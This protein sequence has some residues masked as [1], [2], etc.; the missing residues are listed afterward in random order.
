M[1]RSTTTPG[2]S[3]FM[4]VRPGRG[5]VRHVRAMAASLACVATAFGAHIISGGHASGAAVVTVFV[6][7]GA[8]AWSLAGARLTR[9]QLLG[10][11]VLCQVGVHG[12]SMAAET[13]Q[14]AVMGAAMLATHCLATALSLVLLARGEA[15]VWAVAHHLALRPL[16]LLL[17]TGVRQPR[18]TTIVAVPAT[19]VGGVCA[20]RITPVR[21]PPT[22][23][24][25][26][27]T[28]H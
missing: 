28:S 5:V 13:G 1:E 12:A 14:P 18:A 8:V 22:G 15:F 11:L 24:A 16:L 4:A 17:R 3:G 7:A 6:L 2:G 27:L 26:V 23:L 9:L 25:L 20:S 19:R 10:L 21:G